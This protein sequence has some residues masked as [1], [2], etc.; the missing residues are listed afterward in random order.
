MQTKTTLIERLRQ[1]IDNKTKPLGS[2][3]RLEDAAKLEQQVLDE[4]RDR[5]DVG[6]VLEKNVTK[7]TR[8]VYVNSPSNPTGNVANSES[9]P[10][11]MRRA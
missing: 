6:T 11:C 4:V 5:A 1:L 7:K 8:A 10:C 9:P 3:G 2:L